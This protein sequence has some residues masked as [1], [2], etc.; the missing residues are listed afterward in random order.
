MNETCA[1]CGCWVHR[2]GGYARPSIKG[3]S[4]ATKHHFVAERFFRRSKTRKTQARAGIFEK[5]PWGAKGK[6]AVLC[7]E[8]HEELLHNPVLLPEDVEALR[9]LVDR[10]GF[11]ETQKPR[12]RGKIAGRIG[13]LY[14][15]LHVGLQELVRRAAD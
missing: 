7:Y 9:H 8:C 11:A 3:R 6:S 12:G 1:I 15:A 14:E 13:L 10:S 2:R 4:H 5:D